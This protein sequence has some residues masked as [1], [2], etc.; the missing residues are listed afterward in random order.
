MRIIRGKHRGR[1]I[2]VPSSFNARPTTDFAKEALF[3]IIE[4]NYEISNLKVLDLFSGTGGISFEFLS[5]GAISVLSVE[6]NKRYSLFIK[7]TGEELFPDNFTAIN[8]DSF[9]F[10]EKRGLDFDIIFADPPYDLP[11]LGTLPEL[12]MN[13][14]T[15]KDDTVLILEHSAENDFSDFEYYINTRKYGKVNF[16]FFSKEKD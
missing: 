4:N 14:K 10:I 15:I 1:R 13:S 7:K 12:I 6:K 2:H 11:E 3:N 16:S 5:R 9:R 8:S